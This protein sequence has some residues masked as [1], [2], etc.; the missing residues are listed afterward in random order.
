MATKKPTT[1]HSEMMES[2]LTE[3]MAKCD[4]LSYVDF[5]QEDPENA[6]IIRSGIQPLDWMLGGGLRGGRMTE[7]FGPN[8]SAKTE[9]VRAFSENFLTD[10]PDSKVWYYDQEFA[11][12]EAILRKYPVF[13]ALDPSGRKRFA[14]FRADT[15]EVFFSV[16]FKSFKAAIQ[17][18]A[19]R[20]PLLI[21][22]DSFPALR[23]KVEIESDDFAKVIMM[24]QAR[25]SSE[26]LPKLR[27]FLAKTGVHF[28]IVNQTRDKPN[29]PAFVEQESPGGNAIK[30]YSDYRLI[31]KP[32]SRFSFSKGKN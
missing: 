30:F 19:T 10:Y 11:L 20:I 13:K 23:P 25:I 16:L 3:A 26:C 12:N 17:A 4:E 1:T 18:G 21:V 14:S 27:G 8:K 29:Q 2:A 7:I 6:M 9:I 32:I 24:A 31:T 28:M 5:E 22:L 15:M